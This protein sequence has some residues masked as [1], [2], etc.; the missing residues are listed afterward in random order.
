VDYFK[1]AILWLFRS[2]FIEELPWDI[3]EWT[4]KNFPSLGLPHYLATHPKGVIEFY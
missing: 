4:W 2:G 1:D 3:G